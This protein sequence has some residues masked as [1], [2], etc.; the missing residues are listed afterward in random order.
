M[1]AGWYVAL[2]ATKSAI[3]AVKSPGCV[4]AMSSCSLGSAVR[5]KRQPPGAIFWLHAVASIGGTGM[6]ALGE[7]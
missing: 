1:Y 7:K 4:A 3:M 5:L 2:S 6:D